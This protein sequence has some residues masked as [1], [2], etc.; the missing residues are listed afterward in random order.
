MADVNDMFNDITKEQSFYIPGTKKEKNITPIVEGD[1][2]CHIT[3]VSTKILDVQGKYKARLYSYTVEVAE[4][5]KDMDYEFVEIN[6][7]KKNTKGHVYVGKRFFGKL[8]RF[9]EPTE[10]DTFESNSTGNTNYLRFCETIG[11]DCPKEVKSINGQDIEVQILPSLVSEDML[12]Q[13][14]TAFVALGKPWTDKSGQRKQ[15]FDCKFCKKW[16]GGKKKVIAGG[17]K[18]DIPF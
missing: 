3:D 15:Y 18:D 10:K 2:L 14:I 5:N 8:W 12:G 11:V 7:D 16:D 9:L 1:Y 13:P 4:E 17:K 6:G